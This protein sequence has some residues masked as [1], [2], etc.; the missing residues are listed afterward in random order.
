MRSSSGVG[1]AHVLPA[2]QVVEH[3]RLT[4]PSKEMA[5]D[6]RHHLDAGTGSTLTKRTDSYILILQLVGVEFRALPRRSNQAEVC[7][8]GSHKGLCQLRA[9]RGVAVDNEV[10]LTR[11]LQT[12]VVDGKPSR[13]VLA[14]GYSSCQVRAV[15]CWLVHCVPWLYALRIL[16][17]R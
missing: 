8:V 14:P 7:G 5:S 17:C 11:A 13:W 15:C 12:E 10:D 2:E 16:T 4:L 1:V 9:M 3:L 6:G